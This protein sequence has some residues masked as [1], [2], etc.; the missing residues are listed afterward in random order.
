RYRA[1][2][3]QPAER[4]ADNAAGKRRGR[5]VRS[6]RPDDNGRQAY[7]SSV[8]KAFARVVVDEQFADGLLGAVGRLRRLRDG[9]IDHV[10]Q[11]TTE[12]GYR[13]G[14]DQA[15]WVWQS[16]AR[17]ENRQGAVQVDAHAEVKI[18]F[19]RRAHDRGEV[20]DTGGAR[21]NDL[22]QCGSVG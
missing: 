3:L 4:F 14:E 17:F 20:E 2:R 1:H 16:A 7:G 18:G 12:A 5:P 13:T 19:G 21:I 9:V 22:G 8:D 10:R 11:W 15:W 6:A